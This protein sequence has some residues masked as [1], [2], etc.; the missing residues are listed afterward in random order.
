MIKDI[1]V[2]RSDTTNAISISIPATELIQLF[3]LEKVQDRFVG[4]RIAQDTICAI[5]YCINTLLCVLIDS[6]HIVLDL[7]SRQYEIKQFLPGSNL[8]DYYRYYYKRSRC[9]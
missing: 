7:L 1:I 2:K 5:E 4:E 3:V 8:N 9:R 6:G